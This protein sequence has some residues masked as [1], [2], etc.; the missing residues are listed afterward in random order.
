MNK[1]LVIVLLLFCAGCRADGLRA[2][3]I[4]AGDDARS[5]TANRGCVR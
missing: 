1:T 3:I 4:P 2:A 5:E